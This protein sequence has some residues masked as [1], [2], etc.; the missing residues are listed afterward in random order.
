MR[1]NH[2]VDGIESAGTVRCVSKMLSYHNTIKERMLIAHGQT[3]ASLCCSMQRKRC[4]VKNETWLSQLMIVAAVF[5][6]TT[7]GDGEVT[8]VISVTWR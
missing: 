4:K 3:L 5:E 1:G 7:G 8:L 2:D 6:E